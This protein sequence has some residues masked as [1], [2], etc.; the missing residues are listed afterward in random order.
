MPRC[1]SKANCVWVQRCQR[2]PISHVAK[3]GRIPEAAGGAS[4]AA[5]APRSAVDR[6]KTAG[7][8]P[9]YLYL[10]SIVDGFSR[11]AYTQ[12]LDDEK[13]TT[14]AAFLARAKVWFAV[15]G[16]THIHRIVTDNG[17]CYRS[18]D[19]ARIVR[20]HSAAGGQPPA[21]R[22]KTR[23]TDVRPSYN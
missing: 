6:A 2:R 5:T 9:G 14:A 12:P 20:P 4:T 1:R 10:H 11:L 18:N 22:L 13:G 19:V 23:V 3:V 8:K 21:S 7:A 16:I 15:H 17:A